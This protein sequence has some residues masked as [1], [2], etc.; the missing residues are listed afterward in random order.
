M[1]GYWTAEWKVTHYV[2][3]LNAIRAAIDEGETYSFDVPEGRSPSS[4]RHFIKEMLKSCDAFPSLYSGRFVG[5]GSLTVSLRARTVT[6][7]EKGIPSGKAS[8]FLEQEAYPAESI[9]SDL[10]SV[11]SDLRE[12]AGERKSKTPAS[13]ILRRHASPPDIE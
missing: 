5:M 2:S 7:H 1:M 11:L 12:K 6:I 3:T 10:S 13:D 4:F 8:L 9:P